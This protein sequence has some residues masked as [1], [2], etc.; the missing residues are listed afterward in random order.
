MAIRARLRVTLAGLAVAMLVAPT[1]LSARGKA[2]AP[3]PPERK[4]A[5]TLSL[6]NKRPIALLQF[7]IV[8]PAVDKTPEAVIVRLDKPLAGGT[9][10][11][12]PLT[13]ARGCMFEARWKFEDADD[14]GPVDLCNDAHIVLVD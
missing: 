14:S 10:V 12:L 7:E 9:S 3:K 4:L 2:A 13:G 8:T 5:A 6:D 1:P 11:D